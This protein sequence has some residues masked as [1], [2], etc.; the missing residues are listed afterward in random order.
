MMD[1]SIT[2]HVWSRAVISIS[3]TCIR[4]PRISQCVGLQLEDL[5]GGT[6]DDF[7]T[8][9]QGSSASGAL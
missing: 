7:P 6:Q 8:S 9:N 1:F 3:E 4:S 2:H 5:S